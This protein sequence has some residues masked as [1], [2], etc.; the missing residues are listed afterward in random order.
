MP[1]NQLS[2]GHVPRTLSSP[3]VAT[4]SQNPPLRR[5]CLLS[6]P[7]RPLPQGDTVFL[8]SYTRTTRK[9][10]KPWPGPGKWPA[11]RTWNCSQFWALG[12][13]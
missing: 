1:T 5:R 3:P 11:C 13:K 7:L 6:A 8:S 9:D 12:G 2:E 10:R 4:W